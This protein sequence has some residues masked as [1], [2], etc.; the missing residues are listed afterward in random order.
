MF[1]QEVPIWVL[2]LFLKSLHSGCSVSVPY[3][4]LN[5]LIIIPTYNSVEPPVDKHISKK[6]AQKC[7]T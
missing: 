2:W 5:I 4:L 1:S 6:T 7:H 3:Q